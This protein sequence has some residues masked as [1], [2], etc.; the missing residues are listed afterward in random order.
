MWSQTYDRDLGDVLAL[1]VDIANAVAEALKVSVLGEQTARIELG[2]TRNPAAFDAY[3]RASNAYRGALDKKGLEDAIADYTEAIRLDPDYAMAY[4]RRSIS[5]S[6]F[7][8]NWMKGDAIRDFARKAQVDARKAIA[9]APDLADGHLALASLL[10]GDLEFIG[11]SQEYLRALALDPG[12]ANVL[13]NYGNFACEMGQTEAGLAAVHR[14]VVLDP[15]NYL[16]HLS[17]GRAEMIAR[18]P[19]EAIL[20]I[21][22]AKALAP[23]HAGVNGLLGL[24]YY[25]SGDFQS[26]LAACE[27]GDELNK[28]ICLAMVEDKLGHHGEAESIL[29]NYQAQWGDDAAV[30]Y[31]LIYAEW[32]DTTRALG[33]LETAARRRDRYLGLVRTARPFDPLR[34]DPRFQAIERELRFPD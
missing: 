29:S 33:W 20:A 8:I 28:P 30:F 4:A 9:L 34:K 21:R 18:H 15:L 31:A 10:E 12:S 2:G 1:Q 32:G 23:D 17:L 5:L 16:N 25:Y 11:A 3:L 26:A 13:R 7:A 14:S 27:S 24:A 22:H 19:A 6:G